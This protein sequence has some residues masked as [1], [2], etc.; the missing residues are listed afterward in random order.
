MGTFNAST[1]VP[2]GQNILE[3]NLDGANIT[4]KGNSILLEKFCLT[5]QQWLES[6]RGIYEKPAVEPIVEIPTDGKNLQHKGVLE[7]WINQ[8]LG[9]SEGANDG[10]DGLDSVMLSNAMYMS[11]FTGTTVEL[12]LDGTAYYNELMKRVSVSKC[13]S[14]VSDPLAPVRETFWIKD[15]KKVD[16]YFGIV[17]RI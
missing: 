13:K 1:S 16:E 7:A 12:P 17:E 6:P 8:I 11:A 5:E 4:V 14:P 15:P 3:V 2:N 10:K 9:K